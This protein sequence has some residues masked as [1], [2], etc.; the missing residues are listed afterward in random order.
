MEKKWKCSFFLFDVYYRF[1][2]LIIDLI[3]YNVL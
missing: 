2:L 3:Y 1:N